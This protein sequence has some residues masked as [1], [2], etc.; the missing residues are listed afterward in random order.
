MILVFFT[1]EETS[2]I[3]LHNGHTTVTLNSQ[4]YDFT[5]CTGKIHYVLGGHVHTDTSDT[6][7]NVLCIARTTFAYQ[8]TTPNFDLVLN[9]YDAGKAYFTRVGTGDDAE[10]TI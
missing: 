3:S 10:F 7:N 2:E 8:T 6:V 9:D 5:G 4:T 1:L